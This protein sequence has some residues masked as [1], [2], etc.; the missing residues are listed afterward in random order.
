MCASRIQVLLVRQGSAGLEVPRV[1]WAHYR[2]LLRV[3][4]GVLYRRVP[5]E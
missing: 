5:A 1:H 3:T 2:G 4:H